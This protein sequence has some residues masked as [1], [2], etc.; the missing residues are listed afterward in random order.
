MNSSLGVDWHHGEEVKDQRRSTTPVAAALEDEEASWTST[1]EPVVRLTQPPLKRPSFLEHVHLHPPDGQRRYGPYFEDGLGP[2]NVTARVGSTVLLDCRIGMLQDKTVTWIQ[3]KEDSIHLLTVGKQAYSNDARF[4][5]NFRYPNNWRL[6]ILFVSRRD[7][8]TYECQVA[9]HPPRVLQVRLRVSAPE[10]HILDEHGH[11]VWDR[12]YKVGSRVELLCEASRVQE[13]P[14]TVEWRQAGV[15]LA[16]VAKN[17]SRPDLSVT[18]GTLV[19]KDTVRTVL[20]LQRARKQD[21]GNYTCVVADIAEATVTVHILNGEL[22]A[23]VQHGTSGQAPV[24]P[25]L[26]DVSW[27]S[28]IGSAL[29]DAREGR[30]KS[31]I[32]VSSQQ[33]RVRSQ[34]DRL[35]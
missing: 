29:A 20:T 28:K 11:A 1:T 22:P 24:T 23:A 17:H 35:E 21:S 5:L 25:L 27:D 9:T 15:S 32:P 10:L 26:G 6:Q 30:T 16:A 13:S 8:A 3:R 33:E 19:G 14:S 18:S 4:S 7:E 2:F 34:R 31:L 12:Y